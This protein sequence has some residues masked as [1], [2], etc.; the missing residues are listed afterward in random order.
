MSKKTILSKTFLTLSVVLVALAVLLGVFSV[1]FDKKTA[2]AEEAKFIADDEIIIG[3]L[4]DVHYFPMSYGYLGDDT[5]FSKKVITS[6]KLT[7]E[8][9]LYVMEALD[10]IVEQNPEYLVVTGDLTTDGEIQAHVEIANLLRQTQNR[11]RANGNEDFQIFVILG[12]HDLYNEEAF[13]YSTDGSA[14]LLPN[15]TRYDMT[16]VYSSLGYPDLSDAEIS[17]YYDTKA[18]LSTAL[19]PYD[20]AYVSGNSTAGVKFVNSSTASTTSI[21]WIY[22]ENGAEQA[23]LNGDITDY[24][25]GEISYVANVLKDYAIIGIDEG[26]ATVETQHHLGGILHQNIQDFLSAKKVDGEFEDKNLVSLSHR[27][28]LPHF[29]S[30]DSLLKDF[31]FYNTFETADFLADLGVRYSYSGHM[32]AN[33]IESRISLNGNLITDVETASATGYN[34]AVR[35]TK[36]ERGEVDGKYAENFSTYVK[37]IETV[38]ITSLVAMGYIDD[39]YFDRYDLYPYITEEGGRTIITDAAGYSAN[40]VLLKIVDNMVYQYI[41]VDFIGNAGNLINELLPSGGIVDAIKPIVEPLINN[42]IV[43]LEDVVLSD[44]VYRG[45]NP[46]FKSKVR[47]AK[48]CGYVDELLQEALN[49][50]V[51]SEGLALFDFVINSY[52]DHIGGRDV[53]YAQ[54][55]RG[56][57]EAL[58]LFK[59][60]TNVQKL[61]DILLDE[62]SGLLRIING[63]FE[64]IDLAKDLNDGQV[65]MIKS[66]LTIVDSKIKW[67]PHS[68]KLDDLVPGVLELLGGMGI[69]LGID[70]GNDGI[71][72]FLNHLIDSYLTDSLYTSLGEIAYGIVYS[73]KVDENANMENSFNGYT[74]YKHDVTLASNYVEGALDTTPTVE[75]GQLPGMITV[76]FGENPKT[77]K[78]IVWFTD[79]TV[80]GTD[81]QYVK[82]T[83]FDE[84][85]ATE[86]VGTCEKYATTTANIDLGVFATLMHIEVN[87]HSIELKGLESGTTY[88]YRVGSKALG[89][90]SEVYTF[91]TAPEDDQ[92]FELLLITDIQGSANKPYLAA[93]AIMA[94]VN[95]VFSNGYDFII[96][97]GD[98]VDNTR[99]WV[100]WEYYLNGGLQKYW[101]S[102]TTVV[103]NGN[104]DEYAYEKPDEE[105]MKFEYEWLDKDA[106]MDSYNYL[107]LH[108]GLSYPEQD[109]TTGAYYSFDYSGVHFTVLNTNDYDEKGNMSEAQIS[110]LKNDLKATKKDY[111]VVIMHKSLYSVGSHTNDFE[112]VAMRNQLTKIFA[113]NE[114][115]LVLAGHDHTYTETAYIDSK[116]K[117]VSNKLAGKQEVGRG[118]GVLYITLGTFGDKYYDYVGNSKVPVDFGEELHDP[119]L[120]NP[121]F[122]KLVYD[123][124]KL[125]YVGYEYDLETG[126]I[127]ELRPCPHTVEQIVVIICVIAVVIVCVIAIICA[128][129]KKKVE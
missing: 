90:W 128:K 95:E 21:E 102:T 112:V 58:A 30:E 54:L 97:C 68:V 37:K 25:Q 110:W 62:E 83:K 69:D 40:K 44:Y 23:L 121:T 32:H 82:G 103:A 78:N 96:N 4:T 80:V 47:G 85:K 109:D 34:A 98:V 87:R 120:S 57:K 53:P 61:I 99:N 42:L 39:A 26:V 7:L 55:S 6:S 127:S 3:H 29:V 10:Q 50:P 70:F 123:G 27:N 119:A 14:R 124:D 104:H 9:H 72:A 71:Q 113:E 114:V 49:M 84:S 77:D 2:E 51:N 100:Q 108:Y 106:I 12:N 16:K 13:D 117:V 5:D 52:L 19:C 48:L 101:A 74:I 115:S 41:D 8:S 63:L 81:V 126:E 89:Y 107:L 15:A 93:E 118:N 92:P 36:I 1:D 64:P 91:A 56:E 79:K 125:F 24:D 11:V 60:G 46:E 18:D 33:D 59:D 111:K 73:F 28:V 38:D 76:T 86:V 65:A 67:D 88:S 43:H 17:A 45:S 116:G 20:D 94:N 22:R 129:C 31:T 75:K 122:G 66:V 105:D 35:Y